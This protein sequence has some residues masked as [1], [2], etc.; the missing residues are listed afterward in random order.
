MRSAIAALSDDWKQPRVNS[1]LSPTL[2]VSMA[3]Q[4]SS[5]ETKKSK[6]KGGGVVKFV[7]DLIKRPSKSGTD[8]AIQSNST[9]SSAF[10]AHSSAHWQGNDAGIAE[11]MASSK[12]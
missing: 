8:S 7:R 5:T 1:S 4:P 6:K 9:H 10:G 2:I 12:Y 11:P 3:D